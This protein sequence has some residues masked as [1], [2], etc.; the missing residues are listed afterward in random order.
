MLKQRAVLTRVH[1]AKRKAKKLIKASLRWRES[2]KHAKYHSANTT[3]T[4]GNA[5]ANTAFS[6]SA[7]N[8]G[9]AY[10]TPFNGI[11]EEEDE[12]SEIEFGNAF[13]VPQYD[14]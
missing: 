12:V 6:N 10:H 11:M 8:G 7:H 3:S 4:H 9:N 5:N 2:H 1:G 13:Y 14:K